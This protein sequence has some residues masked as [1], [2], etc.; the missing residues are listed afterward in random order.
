ML[1]RRPFETGYLH[2]GDRLCAQ[3]GLVEFGED[4]GA[5]TL[6]LCRQL[7]SLHGAVTVLSDILG[8]EFSLTSRTFGERMTVISVLIQDKDCDCRCSQL[9]HDTVRP[10]ADAL[11]QRV[12][13]L[14][15]FHEVRRVSSHA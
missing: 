6:K 13:P 11:Q 3:S 2:T 8:T 12:P 4:A 9:R 14:R 5:E 1:T 15:K 7:Q 10:V